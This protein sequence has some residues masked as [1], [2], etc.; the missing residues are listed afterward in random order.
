MIKI[1]FKF[2]F[3]SLFLFFMVSC[4][5]ISE[6][7][8]PIDY[9][10]IVKTKEVSSSN[11]HN[12]KAVDLETLVYDFFRTNYDDIRKTDIVWEEKGKLENGKL[13][14]ASY[15]DSYVDIKAIKD[16]EFIDVKVEQLNFRDSNANKYSVLDVPFNKLITSEKINVSS[17]TSNTTLVEEKKVEK[18]KVKIENKNNT[19]TVK[20]IITYGNVVNGRYVGGDFILAVK[21]ANSIENHE[22][23]KNEFYQLLEN[24]Y[25]TKDKITYYYLTDIISKLAEKADTN[26]P[27][28]DN[29]RVEGKKIYYFVLFPKDFSENIPSWVEF[30][31][32]QKKFDDGIEL[33]TAHVRCAINNI[34]YKDWEAVAAIYK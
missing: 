20:N 7:L 8:E 26:I 15:K 2:I 25:V 19:D 1:L 18:P 10:E 24:M 17:K 4:K 33:R 23:L 32:F 14:R 6:F 31:I 21:N 12:N 28:R 13:I 5:P 9:I 34:E 16:G 30:E 27:V 3:C 29:L 11:Y 22:Y